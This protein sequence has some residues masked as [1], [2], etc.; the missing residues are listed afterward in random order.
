MLML[1]LM[2]DQLRGLLMLRM[3]RQMLIKMSVR[4]TRTSFA[5]AVANGNIADD[6]L[7]LRAMRRATMSRTPT[8][9]LLTAAMR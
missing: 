5:I 2:L 9:M 4:T 8:R 1:R 6:V 3:L 7:A